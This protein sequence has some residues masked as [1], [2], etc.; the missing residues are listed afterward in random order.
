MPHENMEGA[1]V[2]CG[3]TLPLK[4]K[5]H[6]FNRFH[7]LR[8]SAF[9][10]G[11][12]FWLLFTMSFGLGLFAFYQTLEERVLK[13]ID[14]SITDRLVD[15]QKV[16]ELNGL[17]A[18]IELAE[19]KSESPMT[20]SM[21]FH[22]ST[23]EGDR[24]AGNVPICITQPG[25]DVLV[26]DD[27]GLENDDSHYRFLTT[28]VGGNV[29]SLGKSMDDL[30][31]LRH[32]ALMCSLWMLAIST[33]LAFAIAFLFTQRAERR[34]NGISSA[35]DKVAAGNLVARLPVTTAGDDID[36][37]STQINSSL[38]RLRVTVDSM[39]QVSTDIAHDLKTPLNRLYITIEEASTKSRTGQCV[40]DDLEGAL[41]EAQGINGTFEAL[42][43]IAQIEAGAKKS[44]FKTLNLKEVLE[45]AAEVYTPVVEE[46]EQRLTVDVA[47]GADGQSLPLF[48]DRNL[49]IQ[50]VVNLIENSVNHC[51]A[52]T[53]IAITGGEDS[54]GV[55]MRVADS[56]P[57][58]PDSEREKVFQR[59]YRLERSRTTRGTGLG[60]SLVKAIADLHRGAIELGDNKPGLATT[61]RFSKELPAE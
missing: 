21:G 37:L 50:L 45:T 57:G 20:S 34:V 25:W 52:G 27:L 35:L 44:Q 11:F 8:S 22:L 38:D 12:M 36:I 4:I 49:M 2:L 59:L 5:R 30:I 31:E 19:S 7:I 54:A 47:N 26:G 53:N 14:G 10:L 40:G 61:I 6:L 32:I 60:L 28:D 48:G 51:K 29:L 39:R 41:E 55:W 23:I 46:N 24:I 3:D 33:S 15:V 58:I 1:D 9:R 13:R 18:V 43:R 16:Y 56:G 17:E 42:L